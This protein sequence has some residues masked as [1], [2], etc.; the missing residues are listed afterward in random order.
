MLCVIE[1]TLE[2]ARESTPIASSYREC[3]FQQRLN[4]SHLFFYHAPG[5]K[6]LH[7]S[8]RVFYMYVPLKIKSWIGGSTEGV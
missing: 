6:Y 1:T 3:N 8:S 2:R 7:T 5:P 4:V